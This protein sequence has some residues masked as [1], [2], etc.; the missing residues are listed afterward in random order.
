MGVPNILVNIER[1]SREQLGNVI[2]NNPYT[3]IVDTPK[4]FVEALEKLKEV[5]G[6][7]VMNSNAYNIKPGF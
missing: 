3:H 6:E 1:Q 2:G 7:E 4:A 5:N